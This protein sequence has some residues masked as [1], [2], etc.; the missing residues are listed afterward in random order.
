MLPLIICCA[1]AS[2]LGRAAI[3]IQW[4]ESSNP[5]REPTPTD[6]PE[7]SKHFQPERLPQQLLLGKPHHSRRQHSSFVCDN[8]VRDL[9]LRACQ[10]PLAAMGKG[11]MLQQ[12]TSGIHRDIWLRNHRLY[13]SPAASEH[14]LEIEYESDQKGWSVCHLFG[15]DPVCLAPQKLIGHENASEAG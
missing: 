7:I 10:C 11:T 6:A 4:G 5:A 8:T 12:E 15:G 3:L 9:V 2:M 14:H 1:V 13:Y